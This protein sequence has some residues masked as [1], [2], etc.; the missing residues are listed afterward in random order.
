MPG[1]IYWFMFLL[2][3]LLLAACRDA[4][5]GSADAGAATPPAETED[6][7]AGPDAEIDA[8]PPA[9]DEDEAAEA[10]AVPSPAPTPPPE[11]SL[12]VCLSREPDNL[13]IYGDET[14]AAQAV[15]QALYENLYTVLGYAYQPQGL[16]KLPSLSDGDARIE[17][18]RVEAGDIVNDTDGNVVILAEGV[19]VRSATGEVVTF[20]GTP[21]DVPQ[22]VVDFAFKPLVWSDGTP[23]TAV[24]SIFSFNVALSPRT[25]GRKAL[26]N[27]TASYQ[28]TG[29]R[30]VRWT[31]VP[32]YLD[33][34][35]FTN[36]WMPLPTH[37]LQ[38]FTPAELVNAPEATRL[39]LS[40]GPYVVEKWTDESGLVLTANPYYYRSGLPHVSR[41]T[42]RFGDAAALLD[43]G[44]D[45]IGND[46]L[47][48]ADV[49]A[50]AAA[51]L[52]VLTQ[53]GPVYEHVDFGIN[54]V[55]DYAETRPDWFEDVRV[56]QAITMC[57]DRPRMVA[58]LT[59]GY[60]EIMHAYVPSSHPLY[61]D[62]LREWPYDPAAGNALLEEAGYV[63]F[64]GDGRRQD[65]ASGVPF[66]ITLGTDGDSPIRAR[67]SEI[68]QD[69]MADCGIPVVLYSL[70]AGTWYGDGPRGPLFGRR[71]D[72]AEFAWVSRPVPECGLF[73]SDNITGPEEF[74]FGGWRNVNVT[75]YSNEAYDAACR[76]AQRAL[77]GGEGYAANHQAALRIFAEDVPMIPLFTNVKVAAAAPRVRNLQLDSSEPWLLWNLAEWDVEEAE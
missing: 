49:D 50:V 58:E 51:G 34:T 63:D 11:K 42:F 22:M 13:Y 67:I 71:F 17:I 40:T 75:G 23:V 46:A 5:S 65:V 21:I 70:P 15:R 33:A 14:P 74:G 47:T 56:R 8:D 54:P 55:S 28:A 19:M 38:Q 64:A 32:G 16:E 30:S 43:A 76:A 2:A 26:V 45:V 10:T 9:E 7:G 77:P 6:G 66:T 1:K 31:G 52:E 3:A 69:S 24:D 4:D 62:D 44:C 73:L 18:V 72:L 20:D 68:F 36:V 29:D 41:L 60:G 59:G 25:P 57:T 48:V 35:Y 61:P 53:P 27:H 39:P 12:V 37:Q